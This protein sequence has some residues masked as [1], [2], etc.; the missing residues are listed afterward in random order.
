M[1]A[2]TLSLEQPTG[3]EYFKMFTHNKWILVKRNSVS[4]KIISYLQKP[5]FATLD[6]PYT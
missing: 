3:F 1:R 4:A 6:P 5:S 2:L